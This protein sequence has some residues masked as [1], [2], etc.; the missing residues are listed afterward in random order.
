MNVQATTAPQAASID[1]GEIARQ[2]E[3]KDWRERLRLFDLYLG[4]FASAFLTRREMKEL[5]RGVHVRDPLPDPDVFAY[6]ATMLRNFVGLVLRDLAGREGWDGRAASAEHALLL[7]MSA[8][9]DHVRAGWEW[10]RDRGATSFA[11]LLKSAKGLLSVALSPLT[12]S[13][14]V[15]KAALACSRAPHRGAGSAR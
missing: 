6:C 9:A 2:F 3:G 1:P 15:L 11:P 14:G 4:D 7:L 8:H 10:E 12:P 5:L 13:L